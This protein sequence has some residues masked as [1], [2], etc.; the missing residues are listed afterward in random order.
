MSV[1][2]KLSLDRIKNTLNLKIIATALAFVAV[3]STIFYITI[4]NYE[5]KEVLIWFVTTDSQTNLSDDAL[6]IINDY[7]KEKG[8]DKVLLTKRHPDDQYFDV[9]MS[10]VAFYNCDAFIMKKDMAEKYVDMDMFLP[11]PVDGDSAEN[12]LYLENCAVGI[13]IFEDYYFLINNKSDVDFEVIYDIYDLIIE[14]DK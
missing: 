6:K 11:I 4:E 1:N 8:I 12:I 5:K 7:G 10:T 9:A 2:N 14:N 13:L 3:M